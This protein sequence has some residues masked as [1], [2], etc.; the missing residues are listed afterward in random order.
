M[1]E[2]TATPTINVT[3]HYVQGEPVIYPGFTEE[4]YK[5]LLQILD[6]PRVDSIQM[7][8]K[9]IN[10]NAIM[11]LYQSAVPATEPT[12]EEGQSQCQVASDCGS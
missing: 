8:G 10:K 9:W 3:I 12:K 11:Y 6:N 1:E 2:Q 4:T 7:F 5:Q